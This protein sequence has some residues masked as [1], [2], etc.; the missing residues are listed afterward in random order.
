MKRT[1]IQIIFIILTII[2][3]IASVI[4]GKYLMDNTDMLGYTAT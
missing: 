1:K 4:T 3:A 2:S